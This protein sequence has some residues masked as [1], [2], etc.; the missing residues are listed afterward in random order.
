MVGKLPSNEACTHVKPVRQFWFMTWAMR[1]VGLCIIGT[2]F[3]SIGL[4]NEYLSYPNLD[5]V[6]ESILVSFTNINNYY[7]RS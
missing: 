7:T 5:R 2:R 1:D 6:L 3:E 4:Y